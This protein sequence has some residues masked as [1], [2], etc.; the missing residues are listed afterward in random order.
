MYERHLRNNPQISRDLDNKGRLLDG[1]HSGRGVVSPLENPWCFLVLP[2]RHSLHEMIR[3]FYLKTLQELP[4]PLNPSL[5]VLRKGNFFQKFPDLLDTDTWGS[6][7]SNFRNP[8]HGVMKVKVDQESTNIRLCMTRYDRSRGL[9]LKKP[10]AGNWQAKSPFLDW[11]KRDRTHATQSF[12]SIQQE[13][14][15]QSTRLTAL[16]TL[17]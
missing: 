10:L 14:N 8:Y 2:G 4:I 6:G 13:Q 5:S 1:W 15:L 12:T 7:I 17:P 11:P 16:N 3:I 9:E